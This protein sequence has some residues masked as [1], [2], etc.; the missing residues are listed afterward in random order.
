LERERASHDACGLIIANL[1]YAQPL[2]G[3][4]SASLGIPPPSAGLIVTLPLDGY[5]IGLLTIVPLGDLY[6]NRWLALPL[7][8]FEA[9]CMLA[10]SL[11]SR[12]VPLL[13][14]ASAGQVLRIWPRR[15][16]AVKLSAT[17]GLN[18]SGL[19]FG[20]VAGDVCSGDVRSGSTVCIRRREEEARGGAGLWAEPG[21]DRQDVPL[22][23]ATRLCAVQAAGTAEGRTAG[24]ATIS[25]LSASMLLDTVAKSRRPGLSSS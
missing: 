22:F 1:Y 23:R 6:E 20:G 3:L 14:T 24:K 9:L 17:F 12:P 5:G 4:I 7:V 15:R 2:T 8:G 18:L 13:V 10:V 25:S 16:Y 21:Y 11:I 19:W